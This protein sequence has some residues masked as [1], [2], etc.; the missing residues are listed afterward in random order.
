MGNMA[1][2]MTACCT[3]IVLVGLFG[4]FARRWLIVDVLDIGHAVMGGIALGGGMILA[5]RRPHAGTVMEAA[6]AGLL[7][8]LLLAALVAVARAQICAGC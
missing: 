3:F 6:G 1:A 5:R 4:Q 8:G 2:K 7:A